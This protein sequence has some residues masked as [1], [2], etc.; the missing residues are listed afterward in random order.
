MHYM[1]GIL[2]QIGSIHV[3]S[4][5][6]LFFD[7][8]YNLIKTDT[9]VFCIFHFSSNQ[10]LTLKVLLSFCLFF[11]NFNLGLF[12]KVLLNEKECTFLTAAPFIYYFLIL[13]LDFDIFFFSK[14]FL[15]KKNFG[16]PSVFCKET[17]VSS[18]I[19]NFDTTEL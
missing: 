14:D 5:W 15:E 7:W 2:S 18:F 10:R 17:S 1:I 13:F 9:V 4:I 6:R 19:F 11:A 16:D 12:M 8:P 3:L